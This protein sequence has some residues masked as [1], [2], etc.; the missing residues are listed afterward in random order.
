VD[1]ILTSMDPSDAYVFGAFINAIKI[2][3]WKVRELTPTTVGNKESP[4][5]STTILDR[6][7]I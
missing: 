1:M 7:D 4:D 2:K 3:M 5:Q 6:L